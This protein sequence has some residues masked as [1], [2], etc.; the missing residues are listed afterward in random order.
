MAWAAYGG[1]G[2]SSPIAMDCIASSG[3]CWTGGADGLT[4]LDTAGAEILRARLK[5]TSGP[6]RVTAVY[7]DPRN[8][9]VWARAEGRLVNVDTL[10]VMRGDIQLLEPRRA[11]WVSLT[12]DLDRRTIWFIRADSLGSELARIDVDTPGAK[13]VVVATGVPKSAWL[14]PDLTGGVWVVSDRDIR[15][16]D[17]AGKTLL[18]RPLDPE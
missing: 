1:V 10:G 5:S 11:Y 16:I 14:A 7:A 3:I 8:G 13:P 9:S 15:R 18:T 2:D 6:L 4:R 12:P 17:A